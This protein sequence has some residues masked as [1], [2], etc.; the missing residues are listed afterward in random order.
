[1]TSNTV[2]FDDFMSEYERGLLSLALKDMSALT[3]L[4]QKVTID[5]FLYPPHKI[6]Y[7]ALTNLIKDP[8]ITKIDLETLYIEVNKLGFQKS[9]VNPE[10]LALLA[11]GGYDQ[12]NFDFYYNK[13]KNA[14]LKFAL[15]KRIDR[16]KDLIIKNSSDGAS[17]LSGEELIEKISTDL[18]NLYTFHGKE[19][20]IFSFGD[21]AEQF[22]LEKAANPQD[23]LGLRT[24]FPTLDAQINGLMSGTLTVIAGVAKAGKST[25]LLNIADY[26][27]IESDNPVPVLFISTEMGDEEDLAREIALRSLLPERSITNGTAYNDPKQAKVLDRAIKQIKNSKIM[28]VYMPD[29]NASKVCNLIHHAKLKYNIGL[30]IFDYIKMSTTGDDA[31]DKREDQVLGDITTALKNCAG[32][33]NI[34]I[35]TGCQVNNRTGKVADS[36]RIIRYCNILLEFKAKSLKELESQNFYTHGTHWLKVRVTRSGGNCSIPIRFWKKCSKMQEAE[37][38]DQGDDNEL[39]TMELLTT[40]DEWVK[41]KE[42]QFKVNA[43]SESIKQIDSDDILNDIEDKYF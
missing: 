20:D 30:A 24:G 42:E 9:G 36:D 16:A 7:A 8:S 39:E 27:A 35:L 32:K 18:S 41:L 15:S 31:R 21:K 5:Y 40:P 10:Y 1:M 17:S 43:V 6:I 25:V 3:M 26:V 29:F 23:V 19:E 37:P 22:V 28:H 11:E 4:Q 12:E 2:N 13:V 34:P 33:L 14:F 38:L